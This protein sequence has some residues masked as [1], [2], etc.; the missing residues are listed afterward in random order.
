MLM[1]CCAHMA[2]PAAAADTCVTAINDALEQQADT[3]D[4][5]YRVVPRATALA[6]TPRVIAAARSG[7]ATDAD[8]A[9]L[10]AFLQL[11]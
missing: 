1:L 6:V 3:P 7:T 4:A 2:W 10:A 5:I 11:V 9:A 8:A